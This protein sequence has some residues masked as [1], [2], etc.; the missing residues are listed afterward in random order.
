M[1]PKDS[2][3][4]ECE[5]EIVDAENRSE[6]HHFADWDNVLMCLIEKKKN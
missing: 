5:L 6:M 4:S 1:A 3:S 2:K